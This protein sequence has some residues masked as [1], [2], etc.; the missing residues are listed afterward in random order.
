MSRMSSSSQPSTSTA[1][2]SSS[3]VIVK[4]A[5]N[6]KFNK[7]PVFIVENHNDVLELLLPALANRYLPFKDNLMIHFDSHP[8]MCVPRQMP[9]ENVYE[10][11]TLLESLSIENWIVPAMYAQHITEVAWVRPPWAHQIDDGCYKFF[12]GEADGRIY[13][14][15]TL[16]YFL[17][18]GGYKEEKLLQNKREITVH[19]SEVGES[20][21]ELIKD[22]S[23]WILDVDLD[24]FSTHNPF[25][26]I[27]PKAGTFE[28]LRKIFKI[29]LSYDPDNLETVASFV[30]ERN[31]QLDF[32][33]TIFQHM[34]QHGSLEKFKCEDSSMKEKFEM[35][36][37]LIECLC[38]HYSLCDIDWF[39]VNDAGCTCDTDER[40][41]PHHESSEDE[42][43]DLVKKF[44][45]FLRCL[46]T[47]PT[48]IT[49]ARSSL[50]DYTP[51]HQVDFIQSQVLQSLNNVFAENLAS[52]TL[53]YK[54]T[55]HDVS[56]LELV[57]PR[58]K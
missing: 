37:E 47:P 54:Q 38:H 53:W 35:V 41:L 42:I 18:D 5:K 14:S 15:S 17:S 45:K 31:R 4:P 16:D 58:M 33:E 43:K 3:S 23:H 20:L 21:N 13:V 29:E 27:Y 1:S 48:M 44:E 57:Q 28:K 7:I 39:I 34:A 26:G 46:K 49:I 6:R 56:A 8:D 36:K 50:D 40:Q 32:F 19:V 25:L 11:R 30:K 24:Y 55:S 12:V 2:C 9:A 52:E 10:R 51:S 22:D